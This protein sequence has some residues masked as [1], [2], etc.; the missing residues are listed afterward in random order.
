[1]IFVMNGSFT[2]SPV[3]AE[4]VDPA[5]RLGS[6]GRLFYEEDGLGN[7]VPDFSTAGYAGGGA[8]IPRSAP[9]I[10][11]GPVEGEDGRRLQAIIDAVSAWPRS[12]ASEL[13]A[14]VQLAPGVYDIEESLV[15]LTSG[16][17]LRGSGDDENGTL[18]RAMWPGR[19]PV[20][21]VQGEGDWVADS[22][23]VAV[24]SAYVPVGATA[25]P[26]VSADS[27]SVGQNIRITRPATAEWIKAVEMDEAPARTPYKWRPDQWDMF[28]DRRIVAIEGNTLFLDAALTTAL[29]PQYGGGM[30]QAF[31]SPGWLEQVGVENLRI[32]AEVDAENPVD[33]EH[34]WIGVQFDAVQDGWVADVTGQHLVSSLVDLTRRTRRITV[35]DCRS[36]KPVSEIAG[37]R[38]ISFFTRGQQTLFQR[39]FAEDGIHDFV[40][41]N[42]TTGPNVFLES[43][44]RLPHAWSGSVGS[45]A[46]GLLF[47]NVDLDGNAISFD[48]LGMWNQGVGWSAANSMIWQSTASLMIVRSPPTATNWADGVWAQF[49]GDGLWMHTSEFTHP[50]SLY[51]Q[52]LVDRLGADAEKVLNPLGPP[53]PDRTLSVSEAIPDLAERLAPKPPFPGRELVLE[54]GWLS[55]N[56]A[57]LHGDEQ[58]ITW[59]R[60]SVVP[61]RAAT[62]GRSITRFVPGMRG[63]GLTD[64]LDALTDAMVAENKV[65]LR[66]HYGLW[67]DRRRDDHE[68]T[69]RISADVWPPFFE[70]PWARSGQGET[71]NRL[72]RYD[73]TRFN[74]WYFQRLQE[75]AEESRQKG[76][77]LVNE[78]YFQ[79]N[80]IESGAH[81]VDFPW[82]PENALQE[83]GFP[84]PPPWIGDTIKMADDFY[85]LSRADR[86]EWHRRYIRK[87]LENLANQPNVIHTVSA[88]YTGPLHFVEFW[89]DVI[90]EWQEETGHDPLIAISATKDVQDA[91]LEDSSYASLIDVIDFT[92]WYR[93]ADGEEFAPEGG[94]SL[95]PRQNLRKWNG[96]RASGLSLADMAAEYR[97]RYPGK[98]IITGWGEADGWPWL[99][100]GGSLP[101]LPATTAPEL[102]EA[103]VQMSPKSR[104]TTQWVLGTEAG[105]SLFGYSGR[106]DL[107]FD[108]SAAKGR[109]EVRFID[110]RSGAVRRSGEVVEGGRNIEFPANGAQAKWLVKIGS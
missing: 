3:A 4:Q 93:T 29:D 38:R 74:P 95:A 35:Q 17:V 32:V 54:N 108:L 44:A 49:E 46:S 40:A 64:E 66:H 98:A 96:G 50:E 19:E 97:A 84:E 22:E 69:R 88:E 61:N 73:L 33:E 5:V 11:V 8:L 47:D 110:L 52:Q 13:R 20:I 87:C 89:L 62:L 39:C 9:M 14:I 90:R 36:L 75:F 83:T 104:D 91:V 71:W 67:Y 7:R 24:A 59:W 34:A 68:R 15:I 30:V 12:S 85:D 27:F 16:V 28:W 81:W 65:V 37:Y 6:D 101:R 48:N 79:H 55:A 41:G 56:G 100:A 21:Q 45:W 51:R 70:L 82:R 103:L 63:T 78:M 1:M 43:E 76:L 102:L 57:L 99:A 72:T 77:V 2:A 109:F 94:I 80:I 23:V 92:Y 31:S 106:G 25:L 18:L 53:M 86:R 105:D 60:G 42:L 58:P 107:R 26:V 10:E